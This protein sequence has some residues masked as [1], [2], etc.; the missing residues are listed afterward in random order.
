MWF[1]NYKVLYALI[2][3]KSSV[4][5]KNQVAGEE[6]IVILKLIDFCY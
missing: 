3:L 5:V 1:C 2:S 4:L 6:R